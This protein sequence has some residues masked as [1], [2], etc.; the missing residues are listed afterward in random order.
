MLR[1]KSFNCLGHTL[2]FYNIQKL[3]YT[4]TCKALSNYSLSFSIHCTETDTVFAFNFTEYPFSSIFSVYMNAIFLY[5]KKDYLKSDSKQDA[6]IDLCFTEALSKKIFY[7]DMS[8]VQSGTWEVS[9]V[10]IQTMLTDRWL[11]LTDAAEYHC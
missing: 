7:S 5:L 10:Y 1:W 6:D 8:V 11:V 2:H 4:V 3:I 9:K